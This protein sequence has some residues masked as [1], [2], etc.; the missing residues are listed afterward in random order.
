MQD[1]AGLDGSNDDHLQ[2]PTRKTSASTFHLSPFTF[3]HFIVYGTLVKLTYEYQVHL[4]RR[5][6]DWLWGSKYRGA[7]RDLEL[8]HGLII[9]D[10]YI[11]LGRFACDLPAISG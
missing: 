8:I 4:G 1:D 11:K 7:S 5:Q 3:H 6:C 2:G 9:G 10:G